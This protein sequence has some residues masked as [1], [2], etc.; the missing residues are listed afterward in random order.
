MRKVLIA[1]TPAEIPLDSVLIGLAEDI[2]IA[3]SKAAWHQL[4]VTAKAARTA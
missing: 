4:S 1:G 3:L 2:G